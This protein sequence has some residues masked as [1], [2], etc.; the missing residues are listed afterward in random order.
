MHGLG[1]EETPNNPVRHGAAS[2]VREVNRIY[3]VFSIPGYE[4]FPAYQNTSCLLRYPRHDFVV[5]GIG[6]KQPVNGHI[7]HVI[8]A[9]D[10][11]PG[12]FFRRL[13]GSKLS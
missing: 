7:G 1:V 12:L 3:K 10:G 2:E 9:A 8:K 11:S 13:A 6:F 4:I 5:T